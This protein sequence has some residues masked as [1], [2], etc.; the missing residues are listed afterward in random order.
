MEKRIFWFFVKDEE[1][2]YVEAFE[3][4]KLKN[5]NWNKIG[6]YPIFE[7]P[8]SYVDDDYDC[9]VFSTEQKALRELI[10]LKKKRIAEEL[11]RVQELE[12]RLIIK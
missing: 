9:W 1:T 10:M 8:D 5:G 6:R 7:F 12:N 3:C 11:E 4:Q 2:E